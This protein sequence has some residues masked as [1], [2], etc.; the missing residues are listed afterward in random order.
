MIT[1]T[2]VT[3]TS[4]QPILY[5]FTASFYQFVNAKFRNIR[6]GELQIKCKYIR[7]LLI[8]V[9]SKAST[10]TSGYSYRTS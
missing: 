5:D 8:S 1:Q 9:D 3:I 6:V 4:R 2:E 7:L 10:H